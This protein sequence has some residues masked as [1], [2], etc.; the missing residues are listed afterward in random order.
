MINFK[1]LSQ[2]EESYFDHFR[3][4]AWAGLV[5]LVLGTV[6]LIHAVFPWVFARTPDRIYRYFQTK[7]AERISRVN[8]TLK[9]KNLE[10]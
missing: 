9:Q 8:R 2:V 5:F 7:S 10:Q 6:S 3:F 1:H 4:A